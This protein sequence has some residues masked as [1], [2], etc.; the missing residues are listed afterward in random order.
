MAEAAPNNAGSEL[1]TEDAGPELLSERLVLRCVLSHG[2]LTDPAR[3]RSCVHMASCNFDVLCD[4]VALARSCPQCGISMA[5]SSHV[6]RDDPLRLQLHALPH[7]TATVQLRTGEDGRRWLLP[8]TPA[9]PAEA[10]AV[11]DA[12]P[13]EVVDEPEQQDQMKLEEPAA[14]GEQSDAPASAPAPF[15]A[16]VEIAAAPTGGPAPLSTP[17]RSKK[18][19]V[20]EREAVLLKHYFHP[21]WRDVTAGPIPMRRVRKKPG[22]PE[23][24]GCFCT[25]DR[26]LMTNDTPFEGMWI[27]CE[28]CTRWCH[29]ECTGLPPQQLGACELYLCPSCAPS[30]DPH[31][32]TLRTADEAQTDCDA[33]PATGLAIVPVSA[34][35]AADA[36]GL[37]LAPEAAETRLNAAPA[38]QS[39]PSAAAAH[40][41]AAA[42]LA[43]AS[44][45]HGGTAATTAQPPAD[46]ISVGCTVAVQ[47]PD[48]EHCGASGRVVSARSGYYRV[49]LG[50]SVQAHFRRRDLT[51]LAEGGEQ[52]GDG[53][54]GEGEARCEAAAEGD[55]EPAPAGGVASS[56]QPV[57][58]VEATEAEATEAEAAE[59]G[60]PASAP[61]PAR[62]SAFAAEA[63][64]LALARPGANRGASPSC[65]HGPSPRKSASS[66]TSAAS[67]S[68]SHPKAAAPRRPQTA[69]A[70]AASSGGGDDAAGCASRVEPSG[71]TPAPSDGAVDAVELAALRQQVRTLQA[72]LTALRRARPGC[73]VL[74][75]VVDGSSTR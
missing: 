6:V 4:H 58:D 75:V 16:W 47:R 32:A 20:G 68:S 59:A 23:W 3:G 38:A 51:L 27:Q 1:L 50:G 34:G 2:R 7:G 40:P 14:A 56:Q 22:A 33:A 42:H 54:E 73:I 36:S 29:G 66:A 53:E 11:V 70:L 28:A 13:A 48:S 31:G 61:N 25:T 17:Q 15:G 10:A 52:D 24:T 64:A 5:R 45:A 57:V 19:G 39:A 26:H 63:F 21:G 41:A 12:L 55:A 46:A 18:R 72:E 67:C 9:Q 60:A 44:A 35:A 69:E 49:L 43:P 71:A 62:L 8:E 30:A 37:A 65:L 74:S